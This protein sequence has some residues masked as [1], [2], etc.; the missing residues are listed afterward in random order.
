MIYPKNPY[1]I[2]V[3]QIFSILGYAGHAM[4]QAKGD[5]GVLDEGVVSLSLLI[6][7]I[8]FTAWLV[9][10]FAMERNRTKEKLSQLKA[11]QDGHDKFCERRNRVL[12]KMHQK[13]NRSL[14]LPDDE[15]EELF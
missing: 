2:A 9:W 3:F 6:A 14:G 1:I 13:L 8:G 15:G 10:W 4:G 5:S 7:A 11:W 12:K